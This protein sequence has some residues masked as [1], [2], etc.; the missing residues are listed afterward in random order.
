MGLNTSPSLKSTTNLGG[1]LAFLYE[2]GAKAIMVMVIPRI[3]SFLTHEQ[4][5]QCK[6][7]NLCYLWGR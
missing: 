5:F 6:L 2:L 3:N 1:S 4:P 7:Y